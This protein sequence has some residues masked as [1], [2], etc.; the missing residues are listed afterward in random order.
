MALDDTLLVRAGNM[1]EA[2]TIVSGDITT[3]NTFKATVTTHVL[4]RLETMRA[5]M[6]SSY[7]PDYATFYSTVFTGLL[8]TITA[9]LDDD[10]PDN[11]TTPLTD[12]CAAIKQALIDYE[13]ANG[14]TNPCPKCQSSSFFTGSD[15]VKRFCDLSNGYTQTAVAKKVDLDSVNYIDV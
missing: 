2:A 9:Y 6:E 8:S 10:I 14:L 7:P 11:T 15:G 12:A 4:D 3:A 1:D 5:G 13:T